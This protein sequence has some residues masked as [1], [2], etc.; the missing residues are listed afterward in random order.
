ML[1]GV[2]LNRIYTLEQ[3]VNQQATHTDAESSPLLNGQVEDADKTFTNALDSELEKVCSFYQLKELEIHGELDHLLKD[4]ENY[5]EEQEVFE[6]EQENAPPGKKIRSG[7]IFRQIGFNRPRR[8]SQLSRP[9]FLE[10]EEGDSDEDDDDN[11]NETSR[12]RKKSPDG[13]R[14]RSTWG[15]RDG[16][17]MHASTDFASSKRRTSM[18]F[19][20]YNDMAF[21]ALYDEGISLKKRTASVYVSLCELRSF[22]QL[23]K[24]GFS[25]VLKKYDKILDRKLKSTYLAKY[26]DT[27]Q[28][29]KQSTM[30]N[31]ANQI[32]RV[33]VAYSRICTK[34]DVA[35]AKRE[36]RLHLREHVVWER[37]TVWREMI[38]IERKAQAAN[39]GI[40]GILGRRRDARNVRLQ[41]D[42]A[43]LEIKEV[44]TPIGKYRC[45]QW[46]V[47]STF[48]IFIGILAIFFVLLFVPI[49]EK[50]EQQNCLAL[51]VF[52]SLLWATEVSSPQAYH[53]VYLTYD[54]QF[55]SSLPHFSFPS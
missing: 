48:Y 21:S 33:E 29:F 9:S 26:V 1:T 25:K 27:A 4:E 15:S 52:V 30:D 39:L 7:S 37:N 42:D 24:T 44:E 32:S 54:R 19:D 55:H 51:V 34:G 5:E 6:Q 46:L 2:T 14:R 20:D 17:G 40:G 11:A 45:P 16:E 38:G 12:L 31:L 50:P 22:I 36:L 41:G 18:A 35:E 10:E 43:E 49:M 3:R 23:N 47:S 8:E 53:F 13:R 28:P